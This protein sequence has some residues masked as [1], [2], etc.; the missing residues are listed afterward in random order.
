MQRIAVSWLVYRLTNSAFMLGMV[1]FAGQMPTFLLSAYGGV[2]S[3]RYNRYKIIIITQTAA[4]IQAGILAAVVLTGYDSIPA[5]F[6][7]SILLGIINAFDVPARQSLIVYL[8]EEKSLLPNAIALN[9]S[10]V[11][12]ARLLGPTVAGVVLV[13]MG[14]GAC[15][16]INAISFIAVIACLLKMNVS[17]PPNLRERQPFW[18]DFS[19]GWKYMRGNYRLRTVITVMALASLILMPYNTLLPV[20]AKQVFHGDAGTYGWLNALSGLGALI[21]ATNLAMLRSQKYLGRI[22]LFAVTIFGFFLLMFSFANQLWVG[23]LLVIFLGV[24]QMSTMAGVNTFIQ[25][26]VVD[27]MR[28]RMMSFYSMAFFG[29]LPLGS[30]ISGWVA[31]KIGAPLTLTINGSLGLLIGA[32]YLLRLVRRQNAA[33]KSHKQAI[34][35]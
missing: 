27:E 2:I 30:F 33:R 4:M 22:V 17:I 29:M 28:G 6:A 32:F 3:D 7:L 19:E 9:S 12:L 24:G 1:N 13:S 5:I 20:V 15:F 26:H 34:T 23:L 11:N 31:D 8:V 21:A 18:T 25:T 10:V 16:L 14:E 35:T